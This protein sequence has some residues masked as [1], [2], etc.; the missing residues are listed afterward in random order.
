MNEMMVKHRT[1][2]RG[3][4]FVIEF[5]SIIVLTAI[6]E[7]FYFGFNN[8]E[9][10]V[11]IAYVGDAFTGLVGI[12]ELISGNTEMMGWPYHI[13]TYKYGACYNLLYRIFIGLCGFF[14]SDYVLIQNIYIFAIP[15]LNVIVCYNVLKE[16]KLRREFAYLLSL[17]FG[18]CPYVQY[19]V[20][21]HYALASIECIPIV[22]LI[23]FWLYEDN[24]FNL[25]GKQWVNYK[26]NY[27]AIIFSWMIANNGMVY[28]PFFS[29]FIILITGIIIMIKKKRIKAIIP[30]LTIIMEIAWWLMVGF[31]PT[32]VGM[33]CGKG[34]VASNGAK[35]DALR[36]ATYGLDLKAMLLSPK[37]YGSKAILDKYSYLLSYAN[38]KDVAYIGIIAIIGLFCLWFLLLVSRNEKE[39]L[40]SRRLFFLSKINIFVILLATFDGVG[41]IVAIVMPYISCYNRISPFIVFMSLLS[42]GLI[43]EYVIDKYQTQ[44]RKNYIIRLGIV[45]ILLLG[46][47]DIK[48]CYL[49]FDDGYSEYYKACYNQ[50]KE[51][52]GQM[53]NKV[54]DEGLVFQLPYMKS[55]ENGPVYN[56]PDYDHYKG[57]MFADNIRWSYGATSGTENDTW[58]YNTANLSAQAMVRELYKQGFEGIFLNLNGY[59][60]ENGNILKEQLL[61]TTDCEDVIYDQ[62]GKRLYISLE[63]YEERSALYSWVISLHK[64]A[65]IEISKEEAS[66]ISEGIEE[67]KDES[68]MKLYQLMDDD[69]QSDSE[70]IHRLYVCLLERHEAEEENASWVGVLNNGANRIDVMKMFLQSE[71]FKIH[72]N[73]E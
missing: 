41:V 33:F 50:D 26:K 15:L 10:E 45:I 22:F 14:T 31:V 4:L 30:S 73:L 69:Q 60:E 71:E 34:N 29:C 28:Y 61:I 51:F 48:R 55:F 58:Y 57:Y 67:Q 72:F 13:E 63:N 38:E 37:G 17:L 5:L 35:R 6:V 1:K 7:Y 39:N 18:F 11:P 36:A 8:I 44:V 16:I 9:F 24:E 52:F 66:Q 21:G 62:T 43:C 40:Y 12:K 64:E 53:A 59:E 25:I 56:I 68:I 20:L 23:C 54:G 19:R 3:L 32:I 27:V 46:L 70:Y 42:I 49:Y 2:K 65:G 47:V